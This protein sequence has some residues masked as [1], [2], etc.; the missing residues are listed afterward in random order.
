MSDLPKPQSAAITSISLLAPVSTSEPMREYMSRS[1]RAVPTDTAL[2]ARHDVVP[3]RS[4]CSTRRASRH[5]S[6]S[7][8]GSALVFVGSDAVWDSHSTV[9]K[10]TLESTHGRITD[11]RYSE[12]KLTIPP[13]DSSLYRIELTE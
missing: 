13:R 10:A 5:C 3:G 2:A 6:C 4:T 1:M 7:E 12:S 9:S 8:V 11:H